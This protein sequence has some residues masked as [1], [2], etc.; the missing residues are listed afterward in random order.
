MNRLCIHL[1]LRDHAFEQKVS[2]AAQ[3]AGHHTRPVH[4]DAVINNCRVYDTLFV[5]EEDYHAILDL[6]E[7][8][9][10][11]L[12]NFLPTIVVTTPPSVIDARLST[13]RFPY[14]YLPL[15][16][17]LLP[18]LLPRVA[19]LFDR[20]RRAR[21]QEDLLRLHGA[22]VAPFSAPGATF[23]GA[24][25][26]ALRAMLD[27]LFAQKG[28]LMLVNRWGNLIVEAATNRA[29]AGIEVPYD[30][31]SPAWS[32]MESGEPLFCEDILNYPRF[33]KKLD[34]Y[35]KDYFLIVP[36]KLYGKTVGVLNLSDKTVALLFD[37][38]DLLRAQGLL[39]LLEPVLAARCGLLAV[40]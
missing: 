35:A 38:A 15:E 25:D 29:I 19:R 13:V 12:F 40:R 2:A 27:L 11:C 32:V 37:R 5:V 4:L 22:V 8:H 33:K 34:A 14:K 17:T 36:I 3:A 28:S 9:N 6:I 1:A 26:P 23:G 7:F 31:A 10:S 18:S 39:R 21:S 20:L 30:H 24:L 16:R